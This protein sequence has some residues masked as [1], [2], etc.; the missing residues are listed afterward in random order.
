[1]CFPTGIPQT[2]I[3]SGKHIYGFFYFSKLA[4]GL[5]VGLRSE[6]FIEVSGANTLRMAS[7]IVIG[8][9]IG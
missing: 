3:R 6:L 8:L 9:C 7:R 1:M 2:G 5:F 4:T